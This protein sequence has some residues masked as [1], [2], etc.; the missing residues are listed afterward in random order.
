[1]MQPTDLMDL[2]QDYRDVRAEVRE[3]R[4]DFRDFRTDVRRELDMRREAREEPE[5][6]P[7][8]FHAILHD[9]LP[10]A[11]TIIVLILWWL[12]RVSDSIMLK[13]IGL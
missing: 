9:A 13:A 5:K 11:S 1:M 7:S 3:L 10:Y 2:R 8:S 12:G 6:S 4:Q